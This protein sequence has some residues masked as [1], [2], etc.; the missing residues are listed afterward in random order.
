MGCLQQVGSEKPARVPYA[1]PLAGEGV[2]PF[3]GDCNA[4]CAIE[5][6]VNGGLDSQG[7]ADRAAEPRAAFSAPFCP[8]Y[9]VR[10]V[11]PG[12]RVAPA[13]P[14]C[15]REWAREE[16]KSILGGRLRA[17]APASL[18]L[19]RIRLLSSDSSKG[20]DSSVQ[21]EHQPT[22]QLTS[23]TLPFPI[24]ITTTI[25]TTLPGH[26]DLER[27]GLSMTGDQHSSVELARARPANLPALPLSGPPSF[28]AGDGLCAFTC[29]AVR[30]VG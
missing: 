26:G 30:G 22:T 18:L 9:R 14:A 17:D 11:I 4:S 15:E 7:P 23:N 2:R 20:G 16:V 10:V 24:T 25:S 21:V 29:R 3:V 27:V 8:T 1:C 13:H 12:A 19:G 28:S 5:R 6:A